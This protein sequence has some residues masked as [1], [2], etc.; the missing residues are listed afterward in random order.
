MFTLVE[1]QYPFLAKDQNGRVLF[2]LGQHL[3]FSII[4]PGEPTRFRS[5]LGKVTT[6]LMY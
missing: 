1:F 6:L 5:F 3:N 4:G 2:D